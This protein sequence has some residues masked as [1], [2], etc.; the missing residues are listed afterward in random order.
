MPPINMPPR[1]P[2]PEQR[3]RE[4]VRVQFSANDMRSY[5]RQEAEKLIAVNPGSFIVGEDG[6]PSVARKGRG[7]SANKARQAAE[8]K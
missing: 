1:D 4:M 5:T 3:P 6:D 7:S 8:D 2:K